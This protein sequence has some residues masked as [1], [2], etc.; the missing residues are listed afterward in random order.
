MKSGFPPDVRGCELMRPGPRVFYFNPAP[1]THLL[2]SQLH[3]GDEWEVEE[4]MPFISLDLQPHPNRGGS[5]HVADAVEAIERCH[6]H[7]LHIRPEQL[8]SPLPPNLGFFF[9]KSQLLKCCLTLSHFKWDQMATC[10]RLITGYF[11]VCKPTAPALEIDNTC[12]GGGALGVSAEPW[13]RA[14]YLRQSLSRPA[15]DRQS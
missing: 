13:N 8:T 1:P 7:V 4:R 12:R 6:G 3:W 2:H 15:F 9:L 14:F 5:W 11:T 10:R